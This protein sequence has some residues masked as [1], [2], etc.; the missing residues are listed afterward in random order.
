VCVWWLGV[1]RESLASRSTSVNVSAVVSS[2]QRRLLVG[3][4][5]QLF[6]SS[7]FQ[8]TDQNTRPTATPAPAHLPRRWRH[9]HDVIKQ[10]QR[11]SAAVS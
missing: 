2:H 7:R 6:G 1:L 11:H 10:Q 9:A 4:L 5:Q 3:L 8:D